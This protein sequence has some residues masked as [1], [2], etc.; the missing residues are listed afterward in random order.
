M[1]LS[2]GEVIKDSLPQDL[3]HNFIGGRGINS[4][5]LYD[6]TGPQTDPLGP[7]NCFIIGTG[8]TSGT[9]GLGN[10]RF[11]VTSKSP[12]TGILGNGSGGGH[13]GAE[14][15]FAGY[16]HVVIQGKAKNPVY[17]WIEDDKVEIRDARHLWGRNIWETEELIRQE[18]G[19]R[20]IRALTIGQAGENLVKFACAMTDDEGAPAQ[21]GTGAVMGSKNLKAVVAR[22]SRTVK[23]ADPVRYEDIIRKWYE[24][25][26]KQ[27]LA[28]L[29]K[30]IGTPYLIRMFNQFYSLGSKNA[31][32][33]HKPEE[34][35]G[36]LFGENFVPKYLVRHVACFSCGQAC[37]KFMLVHD[38]PYAGE[39]GRRPEYGSLLCTCI[40]LGV[41]DFAF[42]LKVVNLLNQY[43]IDVSG[44]GASVAMAFECYQRGILTR[45]DTDGLKLE[46]GNRAAILELVEK[47]ALRDGFGNVLAEGNV[48]AAKKIGKGAEDYAF[49][50]KRKASY[51]YSPGYMPM[52][53]GLCVATRG[54]DH[55]RGVVFPH[56]SPLGPPKFWD[57]DAR[58]ASAVRDRE[59][60]DTAA[61]SLEI[62]KF[63]TDFEVMQP[64]VGGVARMA[65]VLS[66]LTGVDFSEA[67]LHEACDRIYNIERAYLFKH[68]IRRRDDYPPKSFFDSP[69]PDG[70]SRGKT[71]DRDK[72]NELMDA[73]Y[74]L[75]GSDIKTGAPTRKTLEA[76]NLKYVAD[77]L[78]DTG[79]Y[80]HD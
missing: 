15:K 55:L 58:Y 20:D 28:A 8:P 4:K 35:I 70:P 76:L 19:D 61:D 30:N 47:I 71:L 56:I 33:L 75:R 9:L 69:I 51:R 5:L 13:F 38:G 37:Q 44:F 12:L 39:K 1:N 23:V 72:F 29:H 48:D 49:H 52:T 79:V 73:W 10:G 63:L 66:A 50:I 6:E 68:G 53:L 32:E 25:V 36:Q 21:T 34:E 77:E 14:I 11:T 57:Y 42:G 45:K 7:D 17:L 54:S 24:D 67:R 22:G 59:H 2:S 27:P 74:E 41:Y 65:E 60:I 46:W 40:S 62:C 3:A 18:L 16:D 64:G 31:Q 43:G 80:E 78:E 26:P